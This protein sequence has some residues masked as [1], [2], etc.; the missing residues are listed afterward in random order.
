MR[1]DAAL[2]KYIAS[3]SEL[4]AATSRTMRHRLTAWIKIGGTLKLPKTA[5]FEAART[6]GKRIGWSPATI[7]GVI[8]EIALL[9][10][11]A[12]HPV[13]RGKP[14]RKTVVCRPVP[15]LE[16]IARIYAVADQ[17]EFPSRLRLTNW[18][19]LDVDQSLRAD[20]LRG[21]LVLGVWSGLRLADL[22]ALTWQEVSADRIT[23]SANKTGKQHRIPMTPFVWSQIE[24]LKSLRRSTVLA[25]S[26]NA[27]HLLRKELRRLCE[28]AEVSPIITPQALR[29]AA[30]TTWATASPEAGRIVHGTGLGVLQHYYDCEQILRAAADRFPW[31]TCMLPPDLRDSRER[32]NRELL[33]VASRLPPERLGDVLRV[34]RA[35]AN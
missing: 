19:W 30:I 2:D 13:S 25:I 21:V 1:L 20:W 14:L 27:R 31:P 32:S 33:E 17:C 6:R 7:E 18:S 15:A 10:E 26:I 3:N 24:P 12:G 16:S 11:F 28:I 34:A 8:S 23:R 22:L 4:S 35:F 9:S 29:R 5:E